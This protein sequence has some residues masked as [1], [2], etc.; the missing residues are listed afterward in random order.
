M[1]ELREL[2]QGRV[3]FAVGTGR[4]GTHFMAKIAALEPRVAASHERGALNETFHRYC[5]WYRLPVDHEGFLQQKERE[6]RSDLM[7]HDYSFESS[8]YLAFS[9]IQLYQRFGARFILLVRSPARVV[10]S[11]CAKG[12]YKDPYVRR[13]SN[14]ALGFQDTPEFH[15]FLT[16]I[17]PYGTDFAE[18]NEMTQVGKLAWLWN[19]LNSEVLEQFKQIPSAHWQ[20]QR[21]EDMNYGRYHELSSFL[22]YSSAISTKHYDQITSRRPGARV[23]SYRSHQDWSEKEIEE[24]ERE[25]A[26]MADYF[27]Y[28]YRV[29]ELPSPT[30]DRNRPKKIRAL[31]FNRARKSVRNTLTS[32]VERI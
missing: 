25:T 14:L 30:H 23:S 21:L 32:I 3:G 17:A 10:A 26:P 4:C 6:I 11:Y 29:N 16:R 27:C 7:N 2:T 31:V 5:Q 13:D 15:H 28:P 18:W 8:S 9:L 12:F 1:T 20:V 19:N 22:G 24:F